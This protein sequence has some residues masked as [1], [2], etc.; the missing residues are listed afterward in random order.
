MLS[1]DLGRL[2]REGSVLVEAQVPA[3]DGL[4]EDTGITW[5][6]SVE[7]RLRASFAGSGEVIVRGTV[8]GG[9][10]Q[11]CRRCLLPVVGEFHDELTLVFVPPATGK[12]D[13][14]GGAFVFEPK[15]GGL[16]LS[17]AVREEVMLALNPYVVCDP[18]CLGL[19]PRC[20]A[21]LNEAACECT[22]DDSDPR[23]QALRVLK[24]R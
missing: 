2:G 11:E 12:G 15:S 8:S 13:G 24:D 17:D 14:E 9:L 16:D 1:V 4:W 21:N 23:W 5:A 18:E 10:R 22:E 19:C 7:V 20:G 3:E 6:G